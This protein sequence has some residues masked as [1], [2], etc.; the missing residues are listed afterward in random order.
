[1]VVEFHFDIFGA[2]WRRKVVVRSSLVVSLKIKGSSGGVAFNLR[3]ARESMIG[4]E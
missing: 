3:R 4:L 2:V 1:M